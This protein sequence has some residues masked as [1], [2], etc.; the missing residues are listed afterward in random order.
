[1]NE[2][3]SL[4]DGAANRQ[5]VDSYLAKVAASIDDEQ[6]AEGNALVL[7]QHT[8]VTSN[9]V[10][11]IGQDGDFHL[12][13]AAMLPWLVDPSQVGEDG[14]CRAGQQLDADGFE[15]VRSLGEGDDFRRADEGTVMGQLNYMIFYPTHVSRKQ[16]EKHFP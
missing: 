3:K 9:L 4:I 16:R 14:V 11:S 5:V 15:L 10:V 8:V 2:T 13:E 6:S 12:P 1:M 7:L